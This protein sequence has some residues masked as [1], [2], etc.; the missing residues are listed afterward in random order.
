MYCRSS[1]AAMTFLKYKQLYDH[2]WREK[3]AAKIRPHTWKIS[4]SSWLVYFLNKIKTSAHLSD[5]SQQF[6]GM[7]IRR[8]I[9]LQLSFQAIP[10]CFVHDLLHSALQ[11]VQRYRRYFKIVQQQI[12]SLK[13]KDSKASYCSQSNSHLP[14]GSSAGLTWKAWLTIISWAKAMLVTPLAVSISSST[15]TAREENKWL[16]WFMPTELHIRV[17]E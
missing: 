8:W 13:D 16:K 1:H 15:E 5:L 10:V 7:S 14:S 6:N 9:L 2:I 17:I 4:E 12:T 3:V 11:T